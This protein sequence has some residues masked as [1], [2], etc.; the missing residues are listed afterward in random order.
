MKETNLV[1]QIMLTLTQKVKSCRL[2][3][4]NTGSAYQGDVQW[5]PGHVSLKIDN[6]RILDAGLCKGSSDLIGWTTVTITPEMFGKRVAV[7]TALEV[8]TPTGRTSSEQ[9]NFVDTVRAA[10][11]L[12]F[13]VRSES[14]AI[15]RL[16]SP[17]F[18]E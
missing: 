14:E 17:E 11:G 10:G 1:R 16:N 2:F 13:I 15:E 12:G 6:P 9:L 3:R 18:F 4:N 8:K 5:L 7:F